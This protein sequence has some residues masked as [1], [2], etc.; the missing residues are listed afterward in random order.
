MLLFKEEETK[1]VTVGDE[2]VYTLV[3]GMKGRKMPLNTLKVAQLVRHMWLNNM[4][5]PL[6][7]NVDT[8]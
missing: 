6:R 1:K 2:L 3:L 7:E 8:G 5:R 4:G